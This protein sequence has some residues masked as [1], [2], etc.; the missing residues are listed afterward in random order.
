MRSSLRRVTGMMI[1]LG[2]VL[3]PGLLQAKTPAREWARTS[4]PVAEQG[5]FSM[6]WNLLTEMLEGRTGFGLGGSIFV[7]NGGQLDP[8]GLG[9][10][11]TNNTTTTGDNGGQLDPAGGN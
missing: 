6:A 4:R 8:A 2:L 7:K 1:L 3:M 5:F 11:S 9:T 10:P